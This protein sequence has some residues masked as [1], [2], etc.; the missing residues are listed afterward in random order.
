[1]YGPEV[2][3]TLTLIRESCGQMC[4][5]LSLP[6]IRNAIDFMAE[7]KKLD[8]GITGEIRGVSTTRAAAPALRSRLPAQTH[9]DRKTAKPGFFAPAFMPLTRRRA[10]EAP[11]RAGN[12]I[13]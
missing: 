5:K 3:R 10:A 8:Y 9:F 4:G 13:P 12:A 1:V 6:L 2:T 11:H 7:S